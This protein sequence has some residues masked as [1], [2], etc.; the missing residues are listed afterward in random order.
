MGFRE[1]MGLVPSVEE[2]EEDDGEDENG[3]SS[4]TQSTNNSL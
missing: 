2:D 1:G 3:Y 4:L